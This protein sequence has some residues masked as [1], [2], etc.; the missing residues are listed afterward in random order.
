MKDYV[1]MLVFDPDTS[2]AILAHRRRIRE[3][4][5]IELAG[6]WIPHITLGVYREEALP[7]LIRMAHTV[8]AQASPIPICFSVCGSFFHSPKYPRTDVLCLLPSLPVSLTALYAGFHE[9][10]DGLLT[11]TGRD[12]RLAEDGQ[13]TLHSTLAICD[14]ESY[15]SVSTYLYETFREMRAVITGIRIYNME[16][17]LILDLPF[18]PEG[19]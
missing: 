11:E 19:S 6:D 9:E 14:T 13:P 3:R 15:G 1:A 2:S 4:C 18:S 7:F 16:K 10:N 17:E 12:Y 8:A 5:R